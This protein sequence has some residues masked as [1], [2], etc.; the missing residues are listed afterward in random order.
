MARRMKTIKA[1]PHVSKV[2]LKRP[3]FRPM[4]ESLEV[5]EACNSLYNPLFGSAFLSLDSLDAP[6]S[7]VPGDGSDS[8]SSD[9]GGDGSTGGTGSTQGGSDGGTG[10]SQPPSDNF[11]PADPA[12]AAATIDDNADQFDSVLSDDA[13]NFAQLVAA[14]INAQSQQYG[15][16]SATPGV[17][18]AVVIGLS[19]PAN[20]PTP[21]P[22][23]DD[24]PTGPAPAVSPAPG[25]PGSIGVGLSPSQF[26]LNPFTL[27]SGATVGALTPF[28]VSPGM[29][30]PAAASNGATTVTT[31]TG[32]NSIGYTTTTIDCVRLQRLAGA[33]FHRRSDLRG[34]VLLQLRRADRPG[35]DRRRLGPRLGRVG[36][37]LHRQQRQRELQLHPDRGPYRGRDRLADADDD[38]R[39]WFD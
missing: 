23:P 12:A 32:A 31:G 4:L 1:P 39:R 21:P 29:S 18:A 2:A 9:Q 15:Q 25:V 28:A 14:A 27:L 7:I 34:D 37:H 5:R 22:V 3:S 36:I 26:G 13:A 30:V 17:G 24:A 11:T 19:S 10:G 8:G 33:G 6:Y 20:P 16:P 38:G 35:G